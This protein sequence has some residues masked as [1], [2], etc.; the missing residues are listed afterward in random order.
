MNDDERA[1]QFL[2]SLRRRG[3]LEIRMPCCNTNVFIAPE[4][5]HDGAKEACQKADCAQPVIEEVRVGIGTRPLMSARMAGLHEGEVTHCPPCGAQ[6]VCF[7][8]NGRWSFLS[9][10]PWVKS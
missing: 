7:K 6:V 1:E 8:L 10:A 5:F 9:Q 3:F 4:R 2:D